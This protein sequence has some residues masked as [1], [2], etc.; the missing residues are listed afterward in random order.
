[1][2]ALTLAALLRRGS[3]A[4]SASG[5]AVRELQAAREG[6][7]RRRF[8]AG[9]AAASGA[10]L[11]PPW[12]TGATAA[13]DD[14]PTP[15]G[16]TNGT[17]KPDAK[18]KPAN[19]GKA[20]DE[21]KGFFATDHIPEVE[22]EIDKAGIDSLRGDRKKYVKAKI[23]VD[24]EPALV[25]VGVRIKGSAGSVRSPDDK[26]AL[27]LN[28]DKFVDGQRFRG[29][30]KWHLNNSVQDPSYTTDLLCSDMYR[31]AGTPT[32][33]TTY[34]TVTLNG[35]KQGF[36]VVKEGFDKGFLKA[37]FG[38]AD[39]NLYD[40]GFLQDIDAPLQLDHGKVANPDRADLKAL[41]EAARADRSKRFER[42]E[43]I[44]HVDRFL[45]F[46]ALEALCWDWDGYP[47]Q[48]NNY[49]LYFD[50]QSKKATFLPS[51]MDQMFGD[52]NGPLVAN[53]NGLV[54]A[55][56]ISPPDG[57]KRYLSM[58]R[59]MLDEQLKPDPLVKKL[60]ALQERIRPVMKKVNRGEADGLPGQ[61]DRVRNAI[62][63]RAKN[64]D[65]Q[66]K[67]EKL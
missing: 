7:T 26:P 18:D 46:M 44:L 3:T 8:L 40:G 12:L 63:Q 4:L 56:L 19:R 49:R 37:H 48:R 36:Y 9:A 1:M 55:K 60:D 52:P 42:L 50:P 6:L 13:A 35:K 16:D 32:T 2:D 51:G 61:I 17:D 11:L 14:K 28:M 20:A 39:G 57:R 24:G 34:A 31:S 22:V 25:D 5:R 47:M 53:F 64:A 45:A 29:M 66:L 62:R 30:T 65:Q 59:K 15:A 33:L 27:T 21:R 10:L 38:S 41:V 43:E 23:T 54:A 58:V 67:Q